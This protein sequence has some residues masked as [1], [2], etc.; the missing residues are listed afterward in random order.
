MS[1]GLIFWGNFTHSEYIFKLQK[2][3]IRVKMGAIIRD[4]CREFFKIL[5]ILPLSSQYIFS[6]AMLVVNNKGIFMENSEL[7]NIRTRNNSSLYQP[8]SHNND[9]SERTLLYW[10]QGI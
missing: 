2:R 3:S 7:Y 9:L 8:L 5:Q 1:Y 6:L 10:H 4:S